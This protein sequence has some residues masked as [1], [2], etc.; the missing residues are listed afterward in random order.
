M[1]EREWE[2][3]KDIERKLGNWG[4]RITNRWGGELYMAYAMHPRG[5]G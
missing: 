4:D 2:S 3:E 1:P 5:G